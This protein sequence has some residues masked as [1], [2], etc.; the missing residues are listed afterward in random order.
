MLH[1]LR[2]GLHFCRIDGIFI[3]LDL[4]AGRYFLLREAAAD[5]FARCHAGKASRAD[6]GWLTERA[7]LSAAPPSRP[8]PMGR[9][10]AR[11]R[12][13]VF[14]DAL[15][16][17]SFTGTAIAMFAQRK[18]QFD[19]SYRGLAATLWDLEIA[20]HNETS[21][22]LSDC[23]SVAAAFQRA[24]RHIATI[25]RCLPH[26]LAVARRL[27]ARG[28]KVELVIGVTL[29]FAAHCWV[30]AGAVV[31]TDRIDTVSAFEPIFAV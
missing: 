9:R 21:V 13:S 14:D 25:N 17:A 20:G 24:R 22:D 28:S 15:P 3:F 2:S 16:A 4:E 8:M 6:I 26:S 18:A 7:V 27:T 12:S 11:V 30:Q 29:P 1:R 5:C 23:V 19:L 10:A 31:L